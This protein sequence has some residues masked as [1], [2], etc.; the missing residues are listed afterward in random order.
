MSKFTGPLTITEISADDELWRLEDDLIYYVDYYKEGD[1]VHKSGEIIVPKG[2][3]SDGAS[4]PSFLERWW[5]RWG[6]WRRPAV[7]H[8]YLCSLIDI[9]I[10]HPLCP[11]RDIADNIFRA[12]MVAVGVKLH[13]RLSLYLG[14]RLATKFPFLSKGNV[15]N[16]EGFDHI[17]ERE[18]A[19]HPAVIT[20]K[21]ELLI[22][23]LTG[24]VN[25]STSSSV[26]ETDK[27]AV[28]APEGT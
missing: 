28:I 27:G 25:D 18:S 17:Y 21:E 3:I 14:A 11:T 7:L 15:R 19:K 10:P 8:D 12:A 5:P 2:F 16:A 22:D 20:N 26:I 1:V 6:K 4:V 9:G 23:L 24:L 13:D